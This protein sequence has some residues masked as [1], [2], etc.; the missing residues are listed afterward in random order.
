M[1]KII[2]VILLF[3]SGVLFLMFKSS[4]KA[5]DLFIEGIQRHDSNYHT[6]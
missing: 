2:I 4:E 6:K 5:N 1:Q 3:T